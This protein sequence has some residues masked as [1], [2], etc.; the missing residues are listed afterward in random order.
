MNI[1]SSVNVV[2]GNG[3]RRPGIIEET[4][5]DKKY[6]CNMALVDFGRDDNGKCKG[7]C[8]IPVDELEVIKG[9]EDANARE[10]LADIK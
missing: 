3:T 7:F 9:E 10:R 5:Y 2:L 4:W 6:R 8:T 1:G